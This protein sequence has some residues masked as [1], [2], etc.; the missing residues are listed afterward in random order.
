[1]GNERMSVYCWIGGGV[2][3]LIPVVAMLNGHFHFFF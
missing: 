1:M 3:N 2:V